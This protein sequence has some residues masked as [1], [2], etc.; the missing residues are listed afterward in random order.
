V[1]Y[2]SPGLPLR[3]PQ[4]GNGYLHEVKDQRAA[5][6][7]VVAY[8]HRV[9]SADE[10]AD[11]VAQAFA[12]LR[13]GRPRPVHLEIPV[14][15]LEEETDAP[16]TPPLPVTRP[17]V[18]AELVARAADVLRRARRPGIVAGGGAVDA[19]REVRQLA[20]RLGAPVLTTTNGKG[21]LPEDHRLAL[22]A[23]AHL[24]TAAEWAAECDAVLAVGTELAPSDLWW[25][26][27]AFGGPLVRVD[28]DPAQLVVNARP[29]VAIPGDAAA[30]LREVLSAVGAAGAAGGP[31]RAHRWAARLQ[32]E[33]AAEGARWLDHLDAITS[34][35]DRDALVAADSAMC[36]YYGALANVPLYAPGAFLYP[37]G[38]GT[39]GY[40]LPAGI[41]AKVALPD[42]QV[43]VIMGDG[44]L[45]FTVAELAT[46]AQLRLPLPVVV[47]DNG[48]YGEI[49]QEMS[50]LGFVPHAVDLP[51]PD[52]P[53]LA[54]ALGCHGVEV[55]S[56]DHL[57]RALGTAFAAERPTVLRVR[58]RRR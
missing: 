9:T 30:V 20:E 33:A 57:A 31:A 54:R 28:V 2:V 18:D 38:F 47:F 26:P 40:G 12:D 13:T 24:H 49:R 8:S 7:G 35:L 34:V 17:A 42:R 50:D 55:G 22:G 10:A 52:F 15:V 53:G 41:G 23:G 16:V 58:E 19:A 48:G 4:R 25:G 56:P 39:L 6:A 5:V 14:D 45:M 1:L 27:L 51:S 3:H 11:A 43:A 36:C 46:A 21:V 29:D 44:G 32:D 37:T